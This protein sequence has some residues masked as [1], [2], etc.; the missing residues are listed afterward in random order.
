MSNE[1]ISK[2]VKY[3]P[4]VETEIQE[5]RSLSVNNNKSYS[6]SSYAWFLDADGR[7]CNLSFQVVSVSLDDESIKIAIEEN[8]KL[9]EK[10]AKYLKYTSP[11]TDRS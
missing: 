7:I 5:E 10:Q 3:W 8:R 1:I 6:I 9:I 2:A 4:Y 11:V